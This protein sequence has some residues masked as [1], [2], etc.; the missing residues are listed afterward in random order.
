MVPI[1]IES[2]IHYIALF[3]YGTPPSLWVLYETRNYPS[4]DILTDPMPPIHGYVQVAPTPLSKLPSLSFYGDLTPLLPFSQLFGSTLCQLV[5][6]WMTSAPPGGNL[7]IYRPTA[8]LFSI[9]T[10]PPGDI[11]AHPLFPV[12]D[13][14]FCDALGCTS[15]LLS[16]W[17]I[18]WSG[19]FHL[20]AVN[21]PCMVVG[22]FPPSPSSQ[23]G[24]V[25]WLG[26][27]I[28]LHLSFHLCS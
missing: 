27:G 1:C 26:S 13:R 16:Y 24:F 7:D 18:F 2:R 20:C 12:L 11:I 14:L 25:S 10:S 15:D 17:W 28:V 23:S 4:L 5:L 19:H 6:V 22:L 8:S 21:I 3:A 9:H